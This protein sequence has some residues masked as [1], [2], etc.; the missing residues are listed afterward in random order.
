MRLAIAITALSLA[1]CS[2]GAPSTTSGPQPTTTTTTVATT[3]TTIPA[4][5]GPIDLL[6]LGDSYT[7]A[8]GI[9]PAGGWP[10]QLAERLDVQ[11]TIIGGT[12]WTTGRMLLEFASGTIDLD[13]THDVV[14]VELGVN[15]VYNLVPIETF[16]PSLS[17]VLAQ[18]V[19]FAGGDPRRVVVVSIPDYTLTPTGATIGRVT[20]DELAPYNATVRGVVSAV[21]A[22]LVDVTPLSEDV[23]NDP[24]LLAPD[25]LHYSADMYARWVDLIEP[26]VVAASNPGE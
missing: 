19:A 25:G 20:S 21:G 3:T 18:A 9:D 8:E 5:T 23:T 16:G 6:A 12:G 22:S 2:G 13:A 4:V 14:V 7:V 24:S 10:A 15:D 17:D 1:A 26:A 11:S